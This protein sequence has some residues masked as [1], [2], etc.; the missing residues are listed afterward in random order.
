[1]E[2]RGLSSLYEKRFVKIPYPIQIN[3]IES[4][5]D[6]KD[7]ISLQFKKLLGVLP[8][9]N[10]LHKQAKKPPEKLDQPPQVLSAFLGDTQIEFN[11]AELNKKLVGSQRLPALRR[12]DARID[13]AESK[14][15]TAKA[16]LAGHDNLGVKLNEVELFDDLQDGLCYY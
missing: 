7:K 9:P 13:R 8:S 10:Q 5:G 14:D 6:I 4:R 2:T 1:L 16:A 11:T 12:I 15:L 3:T